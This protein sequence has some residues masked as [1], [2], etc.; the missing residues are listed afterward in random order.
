MDTYNIIKPSPKDFNLM[1][2][3]QI[4]SILGAALLRFALSLYVLDL[5]GRADLFATLYAVS[6]IPLLL[7][8]LGGAIA[9][10]YN[11]RNL[12]VIYDFTSS[13]IV[14]CLFLFMSAGRTPIAL[15]GLVMVLL[16]IISSMYSP[17]V[18]ASVPLLVENKKIEQA[19]GIVT[20]VQALSGVAAP[21]LGGIIYDLVGVNTLVILSSIAFFLSAVMEIFIKIP[22]QKREFTG[23]A[24]KGIARD[25]REGFK[26]VVMQPFILKSMILAA[27]LNLVLS[28]LIL[29][30]SPV[31][32]RV[33][34]QSTDQIYGVGMGIINLA[35][36]LGALTVGLFTKK[37][38]INSVY[39]WLIVT[40]V[41]ILPISLSVTPFMLKLGYYPSFSLFML[42]V[43]PISM[44][45]SILSIFVISKIQKNTPNENLG[46]VMAIIMAVAQCTA[47]VGQFLFGIVFE[48][49]QSS[50]YI[51]IT[52]S[53]IITFI[54]AAAA[55]RSLKNESAS[56]WESD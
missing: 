25:M 2:L 24:V 21:I 48:G 11:R 39:R 18:N 19:N 14:L 35:S 38:R 10:R 37:L 51:P 53:S 29:V 6:N 30:S 42:G 55:R 3:G 47:P 44:I 20:A 17:T 23:N 5:T 4:I 45:L 32:L 13:F 49:F 50:V 15:I 54:I 28:P 36:V 16:S 1:V 26:F 41:L 56:G 9:D 43:V 27:L 7:T 34:M 22:F 8:P 12:M 33:T 31:I 46:K 40:A 52:A